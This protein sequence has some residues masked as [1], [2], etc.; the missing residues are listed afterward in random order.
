MMTTHSNLT[1]EQPVGGCR[2]SRRELA[3]LEL[4]RST[5][6]G[7]LEAAQVACAALRTNGGDLVR[8][9]Q[10][11]E[12]GAEALAARERT[13]TLAE[14]G[15][16]SIEARSDCRKTTLRD[17]R[18]Y[19]RRILK[20]NG[21]GELPLR[22]MTTA[23][24]RDI[25]QRA[26]GHSKSSFVKGRAMLS[27]VFSYGIRQEWC[28]ANPVTRIEVPRV[29]EM[30]IEPLTPAMVEQLQ[31][32][33]QRPEHRAMRFS[34]NLM[35]YSG[36]RPTEVSRLRESD[37]CWEEGTVIIRAQKSKTGGGRVVPLRGLRSLPPKERIIPRG[38][39]RRWQ[40]L[41]RAAGFHKW[42]PDV[43]RHTF[44]SYHAAM[45]RNLPE[46]Q[47]VMGHRDLS[48]LRTRYIAP[49]LRQDA[50]AFW[51]GASADAESAPRQAYG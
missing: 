16:A 11:I 28:D 6:I 45:Y 25:L 1:T 48:L 38:W 26:F 5:G 39:Q 29:V 4:L 41:R 12:L 10:C 31:T 33:A 44:A 15:W 50:A 46:L 13:C 43:C 30:P 22:A 18:Y 47:M 40:A 8:A 34:L 42:I 17:L 14:A 2:V 49:A 32:A 51:Q 37:F 36:I 27:S 3:A 20:L 35:L 19:L 7:L 9:L 24:C 23:Q 21:V